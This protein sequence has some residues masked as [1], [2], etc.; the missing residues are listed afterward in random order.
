MAAS[1][2]ISAAATAAEPCMFCNASVRLDEA[3][4]ACFEQTWQAELSK[5]TASNQSLAIINLA[6]C[7]DTKRTRS[8]ALPTGSGGDGLLDASF[9]LTAESLTCLGDAVSRR[10]KPLPAAQLY[11]LAE[12]C[13]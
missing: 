1:T 2:M 4:A 13:P 3:L 10:Q 9:M 12:L 5:L 7:G 8:G 6:A 11:V